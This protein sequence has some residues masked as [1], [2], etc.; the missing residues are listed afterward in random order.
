LERRPS[1]AQTEETTLVKKLERR[2]HLDKRAGAIAK[3]GPRDKKLLTTQRTAD[4]LGIA[5]S[6]LTKVR[7]F[8]WGIPFVEFPNGTIRYDA[9]K[10]R[11]WLMERERATTAD[12]DSGK[13][14]R[15]RKLVEA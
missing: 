7:A 13:T 14:G 11:A 2:L 8:E 9:D 10:V 3:A 15:P 4:W 1:G 6:W 5:P 12:Y